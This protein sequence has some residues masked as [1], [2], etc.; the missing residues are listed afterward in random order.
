MGIFF[1]K[2]II[3]KETKKISKDNNGIA[4]KE[5]MKSEVIPK[6]DKSVIINA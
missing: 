5:F 2:Y 1:T 4:N 6:V 3:K